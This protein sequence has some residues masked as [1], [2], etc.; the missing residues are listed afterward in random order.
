[1]GRGFWER[2]FPFVAILRDSGRSVVRCD[3]GRAANMRRPTAFVL[4]S[5]LEL[6]GVA[7]T[8][9]VKESVMATEPK[10]PEPNIAPQKPDIQ[11][12]PT[13]Q[14][15]PQD[16]NVPEKQSPPMQL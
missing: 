3:G 4:L 1:V 5:I 8:Y 10:R 16:K 11:P 2:L 6:S 12:E 9:S 14:E 15:I 13:P 7:K